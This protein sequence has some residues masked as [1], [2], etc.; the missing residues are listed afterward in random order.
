MISKSG[1]ETLIKLIAPST[2]AS[3]QKHTSPW[4]LTLEIG[5]GSGQYRYAVQGRYVGIDITI[6]PYVQGIPNYLDAIGDANNLPFK[7]LTFDV[8]FFSNAFHYFE[9]PQKILDQAMNVLKIGGTLLIFDYSKATL[10]KL[11][12]KYT[13]TSPGWN[14]FIVDCNGWI[15]LMRNNHLKKIDISINSTT[16]KNRLAHALLPRKLYYS[17]IDAAETSIIIKGQKP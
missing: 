1:K 12:S 8:V 11:K 4:S 7:S 3:L 5:C 10:S 16:P 9:D 14:A 17:I 13:E 15:T 2:R 6:K